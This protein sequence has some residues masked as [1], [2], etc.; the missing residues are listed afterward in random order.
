MIEGNS[1]ELE[2][3]VTLD[4][5]NPLK[6]G[7]VA[8]SADGDL[9]LRLEFRQAAEIRSNLKDDESRLRMERDRRI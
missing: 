5:R 3:G 2:D 1:P 9:H 8:V 7:Y 6:P 4:S